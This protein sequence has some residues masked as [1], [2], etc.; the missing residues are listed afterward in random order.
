M[1]VAAQI[2]QAIKGFPAGYIFTLSDF[3]VNPENELAVAKLL[4][5][6]TAN[7]ELQKVSKGKYYKPKQTAFGELKPPYVEL[8]KDFLEKDGQ[9]IGYLTGYSVFS[10]MGLSSQITSTLLIGSNKY[11]NPLRR[12]DYKVSFLLQTNTITEE[13]IPLLRILD[14]IK[15]IRG[16]PGTPPSDACKIIMGL[17]GSLSLEQ[18]G[19]LEDLALAYTSYV[20]ALTG[21]M[22]ECLALPCEKLRAS[23]NGTSRYM[24]PISPVT[25]PTTKQ[26]RI[27]E[28]AR[29]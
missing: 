16:I 22:L 11:R 19:E 4:S 23:L 2:R 21:A 17:I 24:L 1:N 18:A 14:A 5:R 10:E 3:S 29:E 6:M 26:W 20:R 28:P 25:L 13:N 7:G 8:V 9:I 27:Y 15:L 12:G